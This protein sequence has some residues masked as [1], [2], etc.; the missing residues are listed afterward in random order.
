VSLE[1]V[2]DTYQYIVVFR[3][4]ISGLGDIFSLAAYTIISKPLIGAEDDEDAKQPP[5]T[6][7][8]IRHGFTTTCGLAGW[9]LFDERC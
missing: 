7:D 8:Q 3:L 9:L 4:Q 1:S 5:K 6:F 2:P